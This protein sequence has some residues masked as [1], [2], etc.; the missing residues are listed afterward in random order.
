MIQKP[1]VKKV[2]VLDD[3]K[4]VRKNVCTRCIRSGKI[5]KAS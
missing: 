3:K 2:K 1:N 4:V 5:V